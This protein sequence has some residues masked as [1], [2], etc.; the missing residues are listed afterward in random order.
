MINYLILD[1]YLKKRKCYAWY[2]NI[3]NFMHTEPKTIKQHILSLIIP[4]NSFILQ[5][6]KMILPIFSLFPISPPPPFFFR[7]FVCDI[8]VLPSKKDSWI[9]SDQNSQVFW[10]Y[11]MTL[12]DINIW[13]SAY[14]SLYSLLC[15]K[16][17]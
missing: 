4:H 12:S 3:L 16:L 5:L 14:I 1:V 8:F 9:L 13:V 17:L 7:L 6:Y 11:F 10:F 15:W 2:T